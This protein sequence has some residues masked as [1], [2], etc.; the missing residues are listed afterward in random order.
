V[1]SPPSTGS[2]P[3]VPTYVMLSTI[4]PDGWETVS[5]NPD[6]ITAVTREVEAMGCTVVC[7]YAVMG[8]YDFVNIIE[9][10]D[11]HTMARVAV[12]LAS[13]GTMR[14]TTMQAIPLTDF[15]ENLKSG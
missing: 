12:M 4:G 3:A 9:A 14:S 13:R 8:Q 11:E 7:Q 6:R 10:P 15:V 1:W 2:V 5:Q